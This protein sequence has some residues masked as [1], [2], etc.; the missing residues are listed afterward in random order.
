MT[1]DNAPMFIKRL[2]SLLLL[3]LITARVRIDTIADLTAPRPVETIQKVAWLKALLS[4]QA[5]QLL[6]D[7]LTDPLSLLLIAITFGLAMVYVL[8]DL[9]AEDSKFKGQ[10]STSHLHPPNNDPLPITHYHLKLCLIY[11][12]V[13]ITVIAQASYLILLR[14]VTGPAAYTHDGGVIQTEATLQF[15]LQ[16]KN[17]YVE[18]YTQTPMAQWGLDPRTALY[19]YPYL[20]W[21]F[22]FSLP[23]YLVSHATLGW[24]D[25]RFVYLLL[26]ILML[27]IAPRLADG[28]MESLILTMTLGL[29]PIMGSDVIFGQNDSFVLFWLILALYL[30]HWELV[31]SKWRI[32]RGVLSLIGFA[33]ACASKPTAWFCAPFFFAYM[34][35]AT[36]HIVSAK[37]LPITN[38]L[39]RL[40]SFCIP[41]L[42]IVLPFFLWDPYHFYDDV[43]AWSAGT[44]PT[45]Y[46]IR[47]W[48]LANFVL[49]FNWVSSRLD[50]FPFWIPELIVCAPLLVVLLRRQWRENTI[51]H[52]AWHGALLLFAYAFTSR[53]FNENYLGFIV[54]LLAVGACMRP[55]V[56]G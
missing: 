1:L 6:E 10:G 55:A 32:S 23:F 19:H 13:F 3:V 14:R 35:R 52:I 21:T 48:G 36:G 7:W 11:A 20:P 8:L 30:S 37:Q 27:L 26:F 5:W 22:L 33:L 18:N 29:N 43:W 2:D 42:L 15:L 38:Y 12:I 51:A 39:L 17:P 46:Q 24:Y 25:Q 50:Y 4:E 16:G 41:F 49:A 9:K 54:G 40:S 28:R 47:G 45:A 44:S 31:I 56:E 53:F 34:L